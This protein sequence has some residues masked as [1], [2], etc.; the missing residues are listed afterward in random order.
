MRT[1]SSLAALEHCSDVLACY[2]GPEGAARAEAALA[3]GQ[4][5]SGTVVDAHE[6]WQHRRVQVQVGVWKRGLGWAVAC[7]S[8]YLDMHG[9]IF[10][11]SI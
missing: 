2:V 5:F 6:N 3:S 7:C 11:T 4:V 1:Y 9:L 8:L 10:E